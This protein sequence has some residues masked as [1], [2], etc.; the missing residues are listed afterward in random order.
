MA[1]CQNCGAAMS[2]GCQRRTSA[3]GKIIGCTK[4]ISDI[5]NSPKPAP[6][7]RVQNNEYG[8]PIPIVN[9]AKL[10]NTDK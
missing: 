9:S 6:V 3:D 4:C 10:I 7:R 8:S 5:N 1:K 2:C